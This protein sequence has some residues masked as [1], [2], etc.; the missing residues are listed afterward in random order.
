MLLAI[1]IFAVILV[2]LGAVVYKRKEAKGEGEDEWK[3][4]VPIC[5]GVVIG[6]I[7]LIAFIATLACYTDV[8]TVDDRIAIYTEENERV[9]SE[10]RDAVAGYESYEGDTFGN[11]KT[12]SPITLAA[13][14]PELK[15]NE[16]IAKQIEVYVAN[17]AEIK[18][19][20][21]ERV[22]YRVLAWWLWF[23]D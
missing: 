22:E 16:L 3:Y 13:I 2:I 8:K 18:N 21:V 11:L 14:Y 17:T 23:G 5:A 4:T 20:Q 12:E 7:A 10:I 9:E 15:S 1:I 19:L 6:V